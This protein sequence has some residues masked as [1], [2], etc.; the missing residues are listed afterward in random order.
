MDEGDRMYRRRVIICLLLI[1]C[2]WFGS[3]VEA[4]TGIVAQRESK[5]TVT[6]LNPKEYQEK[7][8]IYKP[9]ENNTN[10]Q[11]KLPK[12]GS[13]ESKS[14]LLVGIF[15]VSIALYWIKKHTIREKSK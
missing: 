1:G 8:D 15:L 13:L 5:A 2:L 4:T 9:N 12:T 11:G 3:S 14:F 7:N 10:S 6:V